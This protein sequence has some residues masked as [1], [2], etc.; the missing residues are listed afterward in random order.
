MPVFQNKLCVHRGR[1]LNGRLMAAKNDALPIHLSIA[2]RDEDDRAAFSHPTAGGDS[3]EFTIA[4]NL[5]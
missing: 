1:A 5:G 3:A 4:L 2:G